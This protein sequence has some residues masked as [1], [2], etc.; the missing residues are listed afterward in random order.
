MKCSVKESRLGSISSQHLKPILSK[1]FW[2]P[3]IKGMLLKDDNVS[4]K[5]IQGIEW[6]N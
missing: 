6:L 1:A 4:S 3:I 5:Q 2:I